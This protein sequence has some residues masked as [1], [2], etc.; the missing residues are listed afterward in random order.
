MRLLVMTMLAV[1]AMA[2]GPATRCD[3]SNCTGCCSESGVCESGTSTLACGERGATCSSCGVTALCVLGSCKAPS[4]GG[5]AG[6]G[7]GGGSSVSG[8]SCTTA[9]DCPYWFCD[10][11]SGP[12]NSR[13]CI[14]NRCVDAPSSCPSSCANF[15][16]CW[17]GT[18]G[19][20]YP[21]GSNAGPSTCTSTGGGS[22]TTGGGGGSST[23]S[24]SFSDLGKGC[25][26]GADCQSNLCFGT[27]P[28]FICTRACVS[29]NDCPAGWVC[30]GTSLGGK[31]CMTGKLDSTLPRSTSTVCESISF[32][33]LG[34]PCSGCASK[35]CTAN[36]CTRRCD[37][38]SDCPSPWRCA[39]GAS[40]KYCAP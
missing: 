29:A 27:S 3:A 6:T 38:D 24:C 22:G 30:D 2:C 31:V 39:S 10:C 11:A 37:F 23:A 35:F 14:N 26:A 4:T 40:F 9:S 20:G 21:Q 17:R 12:V 7:G 36:M 5:S 18:A 8:P 28:S 32:S 16:S 34:G 25:S 13:A 1:G 33:D 19:G 15:S